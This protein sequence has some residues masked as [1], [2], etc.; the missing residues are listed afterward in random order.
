[1][2]PCIHSLL[3]SSKG[4]LASAHACC[5]MV[6]VTALHHLVPVMTNLPPSAAA[7]MPSLISQFQSVLWAVV[8]RVPFYVAPEE[9]TDLLAYYSKSLQKE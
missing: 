6:A 1:M 3:H 9:Q 7:I 5:K 8:D 4:G 2:N